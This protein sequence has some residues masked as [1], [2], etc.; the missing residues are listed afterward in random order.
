MKLRKRR[1][2]NN[3][4]QHA[5][6]QK[7]E[8]IVWLKDVSRR[9]GRGK[10]AT[11]ALREVNE[12][13]ERGSFTSIMGPSGSGKSTFIQC[14][15]GLDTPT[16]GDV[17]L[18][19]IRLNRLK[20]PAVTETRRRRI[21][22]VFQAFNL[23]PALTARENILLPISLDQRK[24]DAD[25]FQDISDQL[26]ISDLL[27]SRPTELSGGQQQR[28][29]IA[30]AIIAKPDVVFADEPTGALDARSARST[31]ELLRHTVDSLGQTLIMVTHDPVAASYADRIL[32][33]ADGQIVDRFN[34]SSAEVIAT[35]IAALE[36]AR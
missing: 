3:S 26:G 20:E 28:V 17:Y 33:L 4:A 13:F 32:F 29:A 25:W 24:V 12:Q 16:R 8:S 23:L 2:Q 36:V 7:S 27:E 22:F 19:D 21:G 6:E 9:Y 15:A 14:A 18:G 30:R 5:S 11:H 34:R 10:N 35:R 1:R 31:M